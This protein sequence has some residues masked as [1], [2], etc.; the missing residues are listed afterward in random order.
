MTHISPTKKPQLLIVHD[1]KLSTRLHLT[2]L[3]MSTIDSNK[4]IHVLSAPHVMT[5]T[6]PLTLDGLFEHW[7]E[8][9]AIPAYVNQA[10]AKA[11]CEAMVKYPCTLAKIRHR[12]GYV[13]C[14]NKTGNCL[15]LGRTWS[16]VVRAV[17]TN[18]NAR[19]RKIWINAVLAYIR[20]MPFE[21]AVSFVSAAITDKRCP[22][23]VRAHL[24]VMRL[25]PPL[26]T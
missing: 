1:E 19:L 10:D 3:A 18:E 14:F 11:A 5:D 24:T 26:T 13:G 23:D 21:Q 15:G 12:P 6:K 4:K 17:V 22:A 16:E 7:P 2:G 25:S 9:P 20:A 8:T